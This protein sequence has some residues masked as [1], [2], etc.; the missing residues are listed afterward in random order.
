L[1]PSAYIVAGTPR[2][3]SSLL[4]EGL[5][6]TQIAGFPVEPF[7]DEPFR[8]MWRQHWGLEES[9]RIGEYVRTALSRGTSENGVTAFKIQWM[10]VD[11][12]ARELGC[13]TGDVL[14]TLLPDAKFVHI[15]RRD[16][17]AQA[18]SWFRAV[19]TNQWWRLDDA[20]QAQ[21][22][23]LDTDAVHHLEAHIE[24]QQACWRAYFAS[25][26]ATPLTVEYEALDDDYRGTIA[27]VLEFLGLEAA[28]AAAIPK[29]RLRRQ[30]DAVTLQW[31]RQL[32]A[33]GIGDG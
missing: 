4:C 9:V 7:A 17:Q 5:S 12:L 22:P 21:A 30:A 16:R 23:A 20:P 33:L 24:H 27:R 11:P 1:E 18:L 2:T 31:R 14:A 28:R 25:R 8:R 6:A 15:V 32:S 29:P 19:A 10:Q 26:N 3:G 13:P